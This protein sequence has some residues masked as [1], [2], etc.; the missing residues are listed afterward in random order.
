MM[1]FQVASII[2]H[3]ALIANHAVAKDRIGMYWKCDCNFNYNSQ[4][5][6]LKTD[7]HS[8]GV[9]SKH[10]PHNKN[11]TILWSLSN[12]AVTDIVKKCFLSH[13]TTLTD[14]SFARLKFVDEFDKQAFTN[15][16]LLESISITQ[17]PA[18]RYLPNGVFYPV[19]KNLRV[20]R[21][22]HTGLEAVP[23]LP[24]L[25]KKIMHLIDFESNKI[26]SIPSNSI[27]I[28]TEQLVLAY[29]SITKV[30][31][32]AFNGSSIGKLSLRGNN[33]LVELSSDA[34]RG[35]KGLLD[36]D[37]SQTSITFLPVV[38]LEM[39]EMLKLQGTTTLKIIPSIHD[40]KSLQVAELTYSFHCCAFKY[41]ARH[42][43][44]RHELHVEYLQIAK[45]RCGGNAPKRIANSFSRIKREADGS[46]GE[47]QNDGD[48]YGKFSHSVEDDSQQYPQ[49]GSVSQENGDRNHSK[50]GGWTDAFEPPSTKKS[51]SW[52]DGGV[53]HQTHASPTSFEAFCGNLTIRTNPVDCWPKPDA[54]N[55]CEDIMGYDWLRIS[56]WFVIS[57]ALFGNTAVLIVLIAN[58][59]D[60]TVPRFLMM[61]LAFSDLLMA[62]YLLLLAFTDIQSTGM[63]FNYAFDWQRGYGCRIAGTLTVFSS[64]LSIYTLTLITIERW[65]AI[66]HALYANVIDLK[67]AI[68]AM[69]VGWVYSIGIAVLPLF[70]ISSYSTTSICL[71]MDVHNAASTIYVLTLLMV[72]GVAFVIICICY[73]QVYLSLG[74]NTRH[75]PESSVARKM[76]LLV[77]T[78]FACCAPIAFFSLT[79]VA[80][81]PLIDVTR[82]KILLVFFYPI[83]SC[84]NPYL[85]AIM[86]AQYRKQ[87]IQLMAKCG[88]CTECAQQ[89]KMV[90]Q[91]ELEQKPRP[92]RATLL[93]TAH[94]TEDTVFNNNDSTRD[95][96]NDISEREHQTED[97]V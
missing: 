5:V 80:G 54:L 45:E 47:I 41:P 74:K 20:L 52:K 68:Q 38:G 26:R 36:L 13:N 66:R 11:A 59:S 94:S 51:E 67:V 82:S 21:M 62:V 35:L 83:N 12:G 42:N 15:L 24:A 70:G 23:T 25:S 30:E 40:F 89:Y 56:V 32:W 14:I 81:Y 65:F 85:Y 29:N 71:P 31:G 4:D 6:P 43:P 93:S 90:Y 69:I 46:F 48:E 58:R 33:R 88:F 97:N 8:F 76:M 96:C 63:Y 73:I 60:T 55:P 19:S 57:T 10:L 92:S 79:A 50:L 2:L 84:A 7:C 78:N 3:L 39:L 17:S 49:S 75:C 34:F 95:T 53:F 72:T 91:P 64:Q 16:R 1:S 22:T 77:G 18:L 9:E 61:N 44:A 37:L 87:L 27:N 86:T 28:Q